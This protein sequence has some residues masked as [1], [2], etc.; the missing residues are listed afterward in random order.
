MAIDSIPRRFL[1]WAKKTPERPAYFMRNG[2]EWKPT[3]W[4]NHVAEARRAARALIALGF[5]PNDTVTIIGANRPEWVHF[6]MAA[7]LAGGVPA[8][9]YTTSS[10]AELAYIVNHAEA[11]FL[12]VE[13]DEQW[14]KVQAQRAQ[15]PKLEH[16]VFMR[17]AAVPDDPIALSWEQ[18]LAAGDTVPDSLIEERLEG[19][20][21]EAPG[22]FIYTS[23][24]TGPPKAVMLSHW[25][26]LWTAST[27]SERL[28]PTQDDRTISYLPLSHVAE[29]MFTIHGSAAVGLAVYFAPTIEKLRDDILDVRPTLFFG[30][31]RVWEKFYE[32]MRP[33]LASASPVRK[34]IASWA[35]GVGLQVNRLRMSG[36]EPA[37]ALA[38][39]YALAKRLVFSRVKQAI[40]LN[41]ARLLVSGAAPLAREVMDFFASFDLL[42]H[43]VY[44][45]S[46]SSGPTTFNRDNAIKLGTVGQPIPGMEVRLADD[47]EVLVRGPAVFLGYYKDPKGTAEALIDGWLHTGDLG[48]FDGSGFLSITG[49]KKEIIITAGGKNIAPNNIEDLLKAIPLVNDAVVIGDRRK[50]LV[51]LISLK[52]DVAERFAAEHK[53]TGPLHESLVIAQEI[54]KGVDRVNEELSRVEGIRRFKVLAR[55]LSMDSGELTPT[56]KTRRNVVAK[57]FAAEIESLYVEDAGH[58]RA[59]AG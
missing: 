47:G 42:I 15:M 19:I 43:E 55:S 2:K 59:E 39:E 4:A 35:R 40:G 49:R 22:T 53:L 31:P 28:K 36:V 37:G 32:A 3:S 46:E 38:A 9:I 23:G 51:A 48:S 17:G 16:V 14:R 58:A 50:Y 11:A 18:F 41:E 10:P 30:V 5:R 27:G 29:Q 56:M 34:A 7:M 26:L 45:Q 1:A 25:N 21:L 57:N 52:P 20:R 44:G 13:N 8:G 12:L 54:Q 33:R 6:D 24:T